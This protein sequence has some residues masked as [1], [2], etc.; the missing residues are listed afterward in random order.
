MA[1]AGKHWSASGIERHWFERHW[2][3]GGAG[4]RE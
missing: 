4:V 2:F 3:P 1:R